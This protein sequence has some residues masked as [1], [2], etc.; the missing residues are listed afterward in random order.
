MVVARGSASSGGKGSRSASGRSCPKIFLQCHNAWTE[1]IP[2]VLDNAVQFA[3]QHRGLHV[4][5]FKVHAPDM[6]ALNWAR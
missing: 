3:G 1:G 2:I 4:V 5:Q 6:G